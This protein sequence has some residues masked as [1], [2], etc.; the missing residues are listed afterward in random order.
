MKNVQK[1]LHLLNYILNNNI[2][3]LYILNAITFSLFHLLD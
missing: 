1:S 3:N 2:Q